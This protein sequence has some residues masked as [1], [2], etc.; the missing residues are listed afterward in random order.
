[1]YVY[2]EYVKQ[3]KS[4]RGVYQSPLIW[5]YPRFYQSKICQLRFPPR[6]NWKIHSPSWCRCRLHRASLG[7]GLY[8]SVFWGGCPLSPNDWAYTNTKNI[9]GKHPESKIGDSPWL[10]LAGSVPKSL[11]EDKDWPC[12]GLPLALGNHSGAGM[13]EYS[14]PRWIKGDKSQLCCLYELNVHFTG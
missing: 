1:M 12:G 9:S 10:D 14:Q 7:V 11:L 8:I 3:K 6:Y 2:S 13:L 5:R 4:G